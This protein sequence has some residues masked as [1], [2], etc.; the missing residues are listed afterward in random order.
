MAENSLS[1]PSGPRSEFKGSTTQNTQINGIMGVNENNGRSDRKNFSD[2]IIERPPEY[3]FNRY[4]IALNTIVMQ[5]ARSKFPNIR[6]GEEIDTVVLDPPTPCR[7]DIQSSRNV[8]IRQQ[9]K[10]NSHQKVKSKHINMVQGGPSRRPNKRCHDQ[11]W[12]EQQVVF[13]VVPGGPQE[14]RPVI[15]TGIFGHYRTDYMVI[16]TGSSMDI[17]YEQCF[18]QLDP[19]DKARLEPVDFPLT[20]FCNEAVFPLRQIA[21]PVTLSDGEHSRTVTVNFMVMPATSRHDVL[22]GRRSQR[23]FS[24]ITSIPHAACGFPTETGVAILYSSKEVMYVDDEPPAK[25]AKPSIP[26]EPEKWVLNSEYPEQTILLGHTISPTTRE[27]LKELLTNNKDIFA[28]CPADMTGVPRDIAQHCLNIKPTAEPVAQG[29][30][31][32]SEEKAKAM[33]EQVTEL[34]NA[35]ILR[36][37]KYHTWVA[38]PVMVHKHSGGWR[39]C[40]DFKD[41][42]K[43]CQEIVTH[44]QR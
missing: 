9:P 3:W 20:G 29:R 36:E 14:E 17:I 22:L 8:D 11:H 5:I 33:D 31:S 12:R 37:V 24:M 23:E 41:L 1:H 28:W 4:R 21:F 43:A 19:E 30:R 40:V 39:M 25:V 10:N 15:I 2:P 38:N 16:D 32:F 27:Q 35:G 34:L 42:N 13:P 18:K 44:F 7:G 26:D 6:S